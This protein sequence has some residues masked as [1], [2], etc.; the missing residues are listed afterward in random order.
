MTKATVARTQDHYQVVTDAILK[1]L[2]QGTKPWARPWATRDGAEILDAG[3]P[4]NV[5][6]GHNYR[7]LNVPLLWAV[8]AGRGYTS[9]QWLSF[10]QARALGGNVR[11]GERAAYVYWFKILERPE[12]NEDGEAKTMQRIPLLRSYPVFNVAQCDG[13]KLPVRATKVLPKADGELGVVGT[14]V[15]ALRLGGGLRHGGDKAF[16]MPGYDSIQ[17]PKADVHEPGRLSGGATSRVRPR[18]RA[19]IALGKAIR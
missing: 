15:D 2:E 10:N 16:Y 3:L 14:I 6:S 18:H 17:M 13:L 9:H 19:H 11:K 12:R 1:A 4:H 5:A 7:G 8:S